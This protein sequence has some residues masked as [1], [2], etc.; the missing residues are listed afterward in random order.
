MLDN[1]NKLILSLARH[2]LASVAGDRVVEQAARA[3]EF[4]QPLHV[5]AIGKA[6]A[7][8]AA[9][10]QRALP[11]QLR[12]TLVITRP[13]YADSWQRELSAAELIEAGHPVPT[14]DSLVAGKR[15]LDWLAETD[16]DAHILLLLSGGASSLVEV[17][18]E[19]ID[20]ALLQRV[21]RWLLGSGL[22]IDQINRVR[23]R[24][25][26]IKGGGL[27]QYLHGHTTSVWLLS[28]VEG[29]DPAVIGSGLCYP[30]PEQQQPVEYP[31]WLADTLAA[32]PVMPDIRLPVPEHRLLANLEQACTALADAAHDQGLK[33][34]LHTLSLVGDAESTGRQL[35]G[36]LARLPPGIHV[37]GGETTVCLP[38]HPGRGGRNQQLALAA[39]QAL[40]G[41]DGIRLLALG[42]D[43]SDGASEDAGA[44]V[45]GGTIARGELA[46][47]DAAQQLRNA[48]A[49][50]F[51][52]ASGDLVSTGPT[53]TNVRDLVVACV[54]SQENRNV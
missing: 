29:D 12:R 28:D 44:L 41:Q 39:A 20:L 50:R 40:A 32:V 43:G 9:G 42:T 18:A 21:N 27:L 34:T 33:C 37:W 16:S 11:R 23:R 35:A 30:A 46:G 25:S 5:V 10:V 48:D 22:P 14:Q 6:A 13:G 17:P 54:E 45:D 2:A 3:C 31:D 52:E 4:W 19:G 53:G 7:A 47:L 1:R 15:L 36:E 8:M 49:G 24:L 26:R 51:L 38:Q